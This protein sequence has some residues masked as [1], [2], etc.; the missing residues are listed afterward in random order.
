MPR[1]NLIVDRQGAEL[2]IAYGY[3]PAVGFFLD[4]ECPGRMLV[5]YGALSDDYDGL[6]GLIDALI[7]SGVFSRDQVEEALEAMLMVDSVAE[8]EDLD[9][10]QIALIVER[11]KQAA[12]E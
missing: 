2:D 7:A 11:L 4:V 9:I 6:P 10:R 3:D 8:V 12:G 1:W 5:E